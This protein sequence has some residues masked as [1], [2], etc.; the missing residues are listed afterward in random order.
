[1]GKK[2]MS[3]KEALNIVTKEEFE[4]VFHTT[5]TYNEMANILNITPTQVINLKDYWNL[6]W[7]KEEIAERKRVN[8]NKVDKKLSTKKRLNTNIQLYGTRN[9]RTV[10]S[11]ES[12]IYSKE[13]H[14]EWL[15]KYKKT[16][17]EKFGKEFYSKTNEFKDRMVETFKN[18]CIEK[19]GV[20]STMMIKEIKDKVFN[21]RGYNYNGIH[22]DSSW[23][24][25][26]YIYCIDNDIPIERE[27]FS[28]E[29]EYNGHVHSYYPDFLV[30]NEL[31]IEIKGDCYVNEDKTEFVDIRNQ[32]NDKGLNEAKFNCMISNVDKILYSKD[33]KEYLSY[34]NSTCGSNYLKKF[35]VD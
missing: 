34:I 31:L 18:T 35:K 29:Y 7:S 28:I 25:A 24:L 14:D 17:L 12:Y 21:S 23:E 4:K 5:L 26:F 27:P 1:M 8:A 16:S 33:I 11:P 15:R 10:L 3:L 32:G 9:P 22:F 30:N 19:Y 13:Q 2:R 6:K 20:E